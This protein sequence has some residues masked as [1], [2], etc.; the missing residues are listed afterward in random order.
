MKKQIVNTFVSLVTVALLM[1]GCGSSSENTATTEP[2]A[3]TTHSNEASTSSETLTMNG[4]VVAQDVV[5]TTATKDKKSDSTVTVPAGTTFTDKDGKALDSVTPTLAVTQDKSS[6]SSSTSVT[7]KTQTEIKLTDENGNP[8]APSEPVTVKVKAPGNAQPGEEV[9]VSIPDDATKADG[10]K[11]LVI[12]IVD[13]NGYISVKLF[14]AVF[15][16]HT[17]ILIIIEK[18]KTKSTTGAEG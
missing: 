3:I 17:V 12:F 9:S 7:D 18:T 1:V 11:K 5:I 13:A 8:I 6:K 15:K 16:K 14:P 10:Q 2:T 4:G